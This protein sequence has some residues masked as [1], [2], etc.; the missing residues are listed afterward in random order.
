L[1]RDWEKNHSKS[2]KVG[3]H[4]NNSTINGDIGNITG[5]TVNAGALPRKSPR[6]RESVNESQTELYEKVQTHISAWKLKIGSINHI[7]F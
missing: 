3:V 7:P 2:V 6:K 1:A 4:F 5:G